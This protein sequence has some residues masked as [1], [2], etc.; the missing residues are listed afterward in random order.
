MFIILITLKII[1][2]RIIVGLG[3]PGKQYEDSRHN[4]GFM[5]VDSLARE[6]GLSW[7]NNKKFKVELAKGPG[8]ILM[9]PQTFMNGSGRTV[10][11]VL[12]YYLKRPLGNRPTER[13]QSF[14]REKPVPSSPRQGWGDYLAN[15][16]TVVHDDLDVESGKFKISID[17]RSAGHK[18]VESIINQ[19]KTKNFKRIRIG[20]RAPAPGK[21]PADKFVLQK[22]NRKEKTIIKGL[23]N[24]IVRDNY[25]TIS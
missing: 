11:A 6:T 3:N 21:I 25:K 19:L 10:A 5:F 9:K 2:M 8:F 15:I 4:I 1:F 13:L 24:K 16:L 23:I 20:I 17:S 14:G 18:G 22:L 7:Q 12:S